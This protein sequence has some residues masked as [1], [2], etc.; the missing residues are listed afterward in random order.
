MLELW[1]FWPDCEVPGCYKCLWWDLCWQLAD[2]NVE[3]NFP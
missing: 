2:F 3:V 1:H